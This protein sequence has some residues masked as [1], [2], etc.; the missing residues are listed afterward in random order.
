MKL[1]WSFLALAPLTCFG[2]GADSEEFIG[3]FA[4]DSSV[5]MQLV[6]HRGPEK[7]TG[8]NW[9]FGISSHSRLRYCWV[10]EIPVHKDDPYSPRTSTHFVCADKEGGRPSLFFKREERNDAEY[11]KALVRYKETGNCEDELI[12]YFSCE[13][14]CSESTPTL[15]FEVGHDGGCEAD[16]NR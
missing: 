10:N 4:D 2:L 13:V 15:V 3:V 14:G 9:I 12:A 1:L 7:W 5:S 16:G 6:S 8:N 11:Q